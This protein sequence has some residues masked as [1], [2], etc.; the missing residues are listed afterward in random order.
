MRAHSIEA[1]HLLPSLDNVS[2]YVVFGRYVGC[3]HLRVNCV[4]L[5][6]SLSI[7][8]AAWRKR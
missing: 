1:Q 8:L 5:R 3:D 4:W 6:Q 7:H 2:F